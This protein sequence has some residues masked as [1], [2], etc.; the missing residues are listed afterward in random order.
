MAQDDGSFLSELSRRNVWRVGIAYVIA[1]W[2]ILQVLET[3]ASVAG[4]PDWVGKF[5]LGLLVVGLPVA[6]ILA[7]VYEMTPEGIKRERDVDRTASITHETGARLD[8]ITIGVFLIAV[9]WV[10]SDRLLLSRDAEPPV[11]PAVTEEIVATEITDKSIAVLPFM[12]MSEDADAGHFSDG[13]AD[14]VL[15]K[16]AQIQSLRV[17]ARN[18]S[19]QYRG[20]NVDVREVGEELNV[21][22]VLEGSVQASGPAHRRRQRLPPLV[23][24]LRPRTDGCFRYPGRDRA[25]SRRR[26]A[27]VARRRG[28][29]ASRA[30]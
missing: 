4:A 10:V 27:G 17:V 21:A 26:A 19:F 25:K 12:N 1:A 9:A 7:W 18:S 13:L 5:V 23:R 11:L 3:I 24:Q 15:H 30:T 28:L 29:G 22:T 16:L 2:L 14:T 6:L 8:K 20:R